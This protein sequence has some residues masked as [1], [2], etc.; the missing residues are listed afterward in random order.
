MVAVRSR[1]SHKLSRGATLRA[2]AEATI[3]AYDVLLDG[4]RDEVRV[5]GPTPADPPPSGDVWQQEPEPDPREQPA[6]PTGGDEDSGDIDHLLPTRT[7]LATGVYAELVLTPE[8]GITVTPGLRLD[9][10]VSDGASAVA[11]EP[12]VQARIH[13]GK[14][15]FLLH[16]LGLAHQPPGFSVPLP[17]F[18]LG[19]LQGGLQRSLQS[20]YGVENDTLPWELFGSVTGFHS[21]F[22][23][24]TDPLSTIGGDDRIDARSM[25]SAIGFEFLLRRSLTKRFGGFV[26]Y[27]LSRSVR[28]IGI[29]HF[30]SR[31]DRTHVLNLAAAYDLGRNWRAGSRL[32]YYSGFPIYNTGTYVERSEQG[33]VALRRLRTLDA[34]RSPDFARLDL[35]LE[36]RW[37]L[38]PSFSMSLVFEFLNASLSTEVVEYSCSAF[39]CEE[40][41]IGPVSLPS[42]GVE[43]YF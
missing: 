41:R 37:Q 18:A 9:Y 6:P 8:L 31:F 7:D 38:S 4:R 21:V 42:I 22:L 30:H 28:S 3:D 27:T 33:W 17:G 24:M 29:E 43:A 14:G 35:R 40:E 32:V 16:G 36:K 1:V 26:S 5:E 2:G 12:R 13:A 34:P 15:F 23:D 11:L 10:Y 19:G 25:G 39:G 20:S